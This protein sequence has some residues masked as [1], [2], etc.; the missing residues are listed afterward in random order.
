M[1]LVRATRLAA[2]ADVLRDE[3]DDPSKLTVTARNELSEYR[4]RKICRAY[5]A[6]FHTP[7]HIVENELPLIEVFRH[8]YEV[9]YADMEEQDRQAEIVHLT[10]SA[11]DR[12]ARL[13]AEREKVDA[14][15]RWHAEV[16][17]ELAE[18]EAEEKADQA[19]APELPGFSKRFDL[20]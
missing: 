2:L 7:L 18:Q 9:E 19:P 20:E 1:D 15:D 8:Y 5:S 13:V 12:R 6:W 14:E 11:A 17:M 3:T 16:E 4:I 10:E